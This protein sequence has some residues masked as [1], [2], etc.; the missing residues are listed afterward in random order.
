MSS[1]RSH[2]RYIVCICP[3]CN[4]KH[5]HHI[6]WTGKGVPRI[7]CSICKSI[8]DEDNIEPYAVNNK[9]AKK[10]LGLE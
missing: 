2:R 6:F 3:K 4:K 10:L 7:F 1:L 8:A 5:K 9:V